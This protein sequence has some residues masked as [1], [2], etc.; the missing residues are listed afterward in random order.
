MTDTETLRLRLAQAEQALHDLQMGTSVVSIRDA[1]GR[2]VNYTPADATRLSVYVQA[3]KGQ[4][5]QG[6]R[7]PARLVQF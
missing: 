2:Q 6:G 4:L 7:P 3:L 5:G 1:S